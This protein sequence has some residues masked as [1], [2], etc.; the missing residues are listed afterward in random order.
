MIGAIIGGFTILGALLTITAF[1]NGRSTKRLIKEITLKMDEKAEE[2][3]KEV[4]RVMERIS[5]RI[6]ELIVTEGDKTREL[7]KA[8]KG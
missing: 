6:S 1:V 4:L 8:L 3:Q 7:I 2:R 5:E